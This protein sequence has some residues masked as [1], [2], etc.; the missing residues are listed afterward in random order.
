MKSNLRFSLADS[1]TSSP[2]INLHMSVSDST[3]N[4]T[5]AQLIMRYGRF[6]MIILD[7]KWDSLTNAEWSIL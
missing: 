3:S 1:L 6:L 5:F 2:G 7:L 4:L